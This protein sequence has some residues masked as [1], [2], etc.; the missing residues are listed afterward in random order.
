MLNHYD[1]PVKIVACPILREADGLAMSSRNIRLSSDERNAAP[2]IYST[3][4]KARKMYKSNTIEEIKRFVENS[5]NK[6]PLMKLEYFEI[7][8]SET[9]EPVNVIDDSSSRIACIAV[10]LGNIRLIDNIKFL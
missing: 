2:L 6:C 5:I 4:C 1:I 10:Y 3:L 8:N 9:L 7:V